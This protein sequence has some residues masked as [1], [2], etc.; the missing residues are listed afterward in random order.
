M[1]R[2][3]HAG[4]FIFC[5]IIGIQIKLLLMCSWTMCWR[6]EILLLK[7]MKSYSVNKQR[8]VTMA[9]RALISLT[10]LVIRALLVQRWCIFSIFACGNFEEDLLWRTIP[11]PIL[12]LSPFR[13]LVMF[14]FDQSLY[15]SIED[16]GFS[17]RNYW[18]IQLKIVL[19]T[20]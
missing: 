18:L 19:K 5:D 9:R 7:T 1:L 15:G 10:L 16:V 4:T 20:C 12:I 14:S 6:Q 13:L 8:Q 17:C 11:V 2:S 3:Y